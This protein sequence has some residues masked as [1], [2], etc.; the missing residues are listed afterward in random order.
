MIEPIMFFGLGFLAAG[1]L[2][3]VI[4]PLIHARAVRLTRRRLEAAAPLSVSEIQAD[5]DQ[6]R[7]EF[8]ISTRRL[9]MSVEQLKDRTT[10]QLAEVGRKTTAISMLRAELAEKENELETLGMT[11]EGL[12]AK[13]HATIHDLAERT[14]SLEAAERHLAEGEIA[15]VAL[16]KDFEERS[17]TADSQRVEIV[18]LKTQQARLQDDAADLQQQFKQSEQNLARGKAELEQT[19][20]DLAQERSAMVALTGRA[21]QL[22]KE[23]GERTA[24]SEE[25]AR[26]LGDFEPRLNDYVRHLGE[27]VRERDHLRL[28]LAALQRIE[29][30]LRAEFT[31]LT[32]RHESAFET[33]RTEKSSAEAQ[34]ERTRE[35][36]TKVQRELAGLKREAESSWEVDR[37]ENAVLRE[38]INDVAAEVARLT[39]TL[40]GPESPIVATLA[41]DMMAKTANGNYAAQ[42]PKN[43]GTLT[44][45]DRI[46]ALQGKAER[47]ASAN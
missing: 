2:A 16:R 34:L 30:D 42:Q 38:R 35:E 28:E 8:A 39:M 15:F 1:L 5:K 17:M 10:G 19:V 33:L 27:A 18:A 24:E 46:R 7:A 43:G 22:G 3:L 25:R 47:A 13:L 29:S 6:L 41:A 4:V 12:A 36:R 14:A 44:L 40:E 26:R 45:A 31:T 32:G 21:D 20:G 9:E 23:L 11:G 37:A